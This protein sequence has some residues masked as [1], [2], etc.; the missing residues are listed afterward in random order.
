MFLTG[1]RHVNALLPIDPRM[2]AVWKR[3][4]D[5]LI[6]YASLAVLT[7]QI[8]E[9]KATCDVTHEAFRNDKRV[10][11]KIR[12]WNRNRSVNTRRLFNLEDLRHLVIN[13]TFNET[14]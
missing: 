11:V 13:G 2:Q 7:R 8:I 14:V 10:I 9:T 6:D 1:S 12:D 4:H 3:T 5:Q